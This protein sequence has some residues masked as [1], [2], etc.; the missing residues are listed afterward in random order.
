MSYLNPVN[1]FTGE[2]TISLSVAICKRPWHHGVIHPKHW[3]L[4]LHPESLLDP[5]WPSR[6][7]TWIEPIALEEKE[8]P[9]TYEHV[10]QKNMPVDDSELLESRTVVARFPASKLEEVEDVIFE[11]EAQ[12]CQR[13]VVAV[14]E[15]LQKK[16]FVGEDVVSKF[17]KE[18][19]YSPY[20]MIKKNPMWSPYSLVELDKA[21][22]YEQRGGL[23]EKKCCY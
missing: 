15:A 8:A 9:C 4:S 17:K 19:E 16:G 14:L 11:T 5:I 10:V 3:F 1:L 22:R 7:A 2:T 20:L 23:K 13:Y 12:N 18:V 21:I 6:T